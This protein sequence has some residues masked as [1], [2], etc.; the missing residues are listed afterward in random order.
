MVRNCSP[1]FKPAPPPQTGKHEN[2][3]KALLFDLAWESAAAAVA[4][5][6]LI[7]GEG[8]FEDG[9]RN[10]RT[11]QAR[12]GVF[13]ERPAHAALRL[14]R[15]AGTGQNPAQKGTRKPPSGE[16]RGTGDKDVRVKV[17][18]DGF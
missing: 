12:L 1:C 16:G 11:P 7:T 13:P 4:K 18:Y 10:C 2:N 5:G 3:D 14:A 6:K 15:V 9:A 17:R 8:C